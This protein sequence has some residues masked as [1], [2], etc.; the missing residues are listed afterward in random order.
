MTTGKAGV[1]KAQKLTSGTALDITENDALTSGKLL[2]IST[3]SATAQNP[4][5]ISAPN[6]IDGDVVSIKS[7]SLVSGSALSID[8]GNI[9]SMGRASLFRVTTNTTSVHQGLVRVAANNVKEGKI[10][11]IEAND[12]S[13]GRAVEIVGGQNI[14]S[15]SLLY[16][17]TV[18]KTPI[19]G[20]LQLSANK[21]T[22]GKAV[23]INTDELSSGVAMEIVNKGAALSTG[24]LLKLQTGAISPTNGVARISGNNVKEGKILS[25]EANDLSTGR[26]VEISNAGSNLS[27]GSLLHVS[28]GTTNGGEEGIVRVDAN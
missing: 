18:A 1:I 6:M 20:V 21:I 25:I 15:G 2:D 11:S 13:T 16:I 7:K 26:A 5:S 10:L 14:T 24:S 17:A 12:L 23:Q 8:G 4:V 28:T 27:S 3:S 9:S 22:S 19:Q